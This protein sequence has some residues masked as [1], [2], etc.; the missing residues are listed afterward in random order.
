MKMTGI[1]MR[2]N[3]LWQPDD[4]AFWRE[5]GFK[6]THAIPRFNLILLL[7]GASLWMLWSVLGILLFN[8]GFPF[9]LGQLFSLI[10]SAGLSAACVRLCGGFV[11]HHCGVRYAML[12]SAYL[13]W[14][15]LA[16]LWWA[17]MDVH[18]PFWQFQ[19]LAI[20]SGLGAGLLSQVV[21]NSFYLFPSK[22]QPLVQEVPLALANLG[23]IVVLV[24]MP[25]IVQWAWLGQWSGDALTLFYSS[26]NVTGRVAAGQPMWPNLIV[27][28]PAGLLLVALFYAHRLP[29][30]LP[31][32]HAAL[33]LWSGLAR[34]LLLLLSV[35]ALCVLLLVPEAFGTLASA[36]PA[37]RELIIILLIA[38]VL[39]LMHWLASPATEV[40]K[41]QL[42]VLA[43]R[44]V[45]VL[46][47]MYLMGM[48][49]FLGFALSFPLLI[50]AVFGV[51]IGSD[52]RAM[53]NPVAPAAFIYGWLPVILG[54]VARAFGNWLAHRMS[55]VKL[56]Q[57]ALMALV[58]SSAALAYYSY[59]AH[60]HAHPEQLFFGFFVWALLFFVAAGIAAGS[61]MATVFQVLPK[62]Q[63]EYALTWIV[64]L[65]TAGAF[66]I[67]QMF[68][69]HW[70]SSGAASIII[71]FMLF[72][73]LGLGVNWYFYLR[74]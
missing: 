39:L 19:C 46:G 65:T 33:A 64:A 24:L 42:Q 74:R 52:G 66:Y 17:L 27:L 51:Q 47:L 26:S 1:T 21:N 35:L 5:H 44:E 37:A 7:A 59:H 25:L 34:S 62:Q 57:L 22:Q 11:L 2:T 63:M 71:G 48:G 32:S 53:P 38:A 40:V 6:R 10:A 45:Q 30:I 23:L 43:S 14:L 16:G 15:P 56:T 58:A 3:P 31:P 4:D 69:D 20:A 55:A 49:S 73:L 70:H 50:E 13:L 12:L 41:Q 28:L 54:L 61:V 68:A 18:T 67:P 60:E 29:Q 72:Y 36:I 8:L 9:S